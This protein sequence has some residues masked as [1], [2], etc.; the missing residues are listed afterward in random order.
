M[1]ELISIG[2]PFHN[3][4]RHLARAIKSV[5]RQTSSNWE[6]ILLNDGSSDGSLEVARSFTDPRIRLIDHREN[7]G[8][9]CR[10]NEIASAARGEYLF[11]MDADDVMHPA[12][13]ERQLNVL[14]SAPANTV[15]GTAAIGLDENDHL[16]RII[17]SYGARQGGYNAR[18]AFIHPT[19]A[20]RTAWFLENPYSEAPVFRRT[21]D[22]ELWTRTAASSR[23]VLLEEPLLFYRSPG[24]SSFDKYLWQGLA[25]V[26]ILAN[27]PKAGSVPFRLFHCA[28][29][30]IKVQIRFACHVLRTPWP[31]PAGQTHENPDLVEYRRILDALE[32]D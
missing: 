5:L 10:L 30:L 31:A 29:E 2:L 25:L 14:R 11:R 6:L 12:R 20:A 15:V 24:R 26:T 21:Q 9:A 3:D 16:T 7:C 27:S 32:V 4:R 17:R 28:L 1:N 23:F 13:L 18:S 19:V 8:L 22:A